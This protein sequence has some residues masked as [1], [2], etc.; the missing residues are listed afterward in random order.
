MLIY[1]VPQIR[2]PEIDFLVSF[3]LKAVRTQVVHLNNAEEFQ[4]QKL[5]AASPCASA[6][7][8]ETSP[9]KAAAHESD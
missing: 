1:T 5:S 9:I 7:Y 4:V 8:N 2:N 6:L 3:T